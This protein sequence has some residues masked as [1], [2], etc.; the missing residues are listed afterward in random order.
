MLERPVPL[1]LSYVAP[2]RCP[3]YR[4]PYHPAYRGS[5]ARRCTK[6]VRAGA[7]VTVRHVTIEL[8]DG[9]EVPATP[10]EK[11]F[12]KKPTIGHLRHFGCPVI[13]KIGD[14]CEQD[15]N[16]VLHTRNIV[17]RGIRGIFVGFPLNQAGW[18][19]FVPYTGEF[20]VSCDVAFDEH[21]HSSLAYDHHSFNGAYPLHIATTNVDPLQAYHL[22]HPVTPTLIQ[23]MVIPNLLLNLIP[24]L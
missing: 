5:H 20:Y 13:F 23:P 12:S 10:F 4:I 14:K 7:S 1:R 24:L 9:S 15:T 18:L 16:H 8:P 21:F 22:L 19:I 11:F 17:Q 2:G 3:G 6:W